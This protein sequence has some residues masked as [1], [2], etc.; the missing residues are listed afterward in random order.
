[1][2]VSKEHIKQE[3]DNLNEEQL[4]EVADLITSLKFRTQTIEKTPKKRLSEFYGVLHTTI[5]YPGKEAIRQI[6]G[7]TLAQKNST[8]KS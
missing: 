6:V 8:E 2:T 1:M 4:E 7:E 5:A 3:L